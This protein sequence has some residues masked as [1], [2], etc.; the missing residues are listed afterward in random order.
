MSTETLRNVGVV[1]L[2]A[3]AVFLLPLPSNV[4]GVIAVWRSAA[5]Y[6]GDPTWAQAARIAII[7]WAIFATLI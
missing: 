2:L 7:A 4:L 1:I 3:L 6:G 5:C